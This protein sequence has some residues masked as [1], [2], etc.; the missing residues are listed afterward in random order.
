MCSAS[1][2]LSTPVVNGPTHKPVTR[3][4]QRCLDLMQTLP[5]ATPA[6]I[7]WARSKMAALGYFVTRGRHGKNSAVWCQECGHMDEVGLPPL[8]VDITKVGHVCSRCGR[9]LDV[10]HWSSRN[11][12]VQH[13]FHFAVVSACEDF[14]VARVFCINQYNAMGC[15]TQELIDNVFNVFVEIRTGKE[16]II[17]RKY[18]RNYNYFRWNFYE[19]YR[20]ARHCQ[21][22]SG[23]YVYEDIYDLSNMYIFPHMKIHPLLRRNGW[24]NR[25]THMRTSPV[26][27]WRGLLS[28]PAIEALAKNLQY[29]I[30]D[31][32]FSTG[33]PRR[34]K[35]SWM[36]IIR[37]CNRHHYIVNDAS[38]WFDYIDL[39]EYFH[40]DTRSPHYVCPAN[41]KQEHDRLLQKKKRIEDAKELR[42]QIA[43]SNKFEEQ[44]RKHRGRFFGICFGN[45]QITV[46]VISSVREMAEEGTA[47][48][49]CVYFNRY[50]DHKSHPDSLILSARDKNGR[51]L[52]TVEVNVKTWQVIQS[53]GVGNLP[54]PFHDQIVDI[55]RQ[56]IHLFK[57]AV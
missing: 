12:E 47:M 39:L 29:N 6:Q 37:I 57:K 11:K 30:I 28:D 23:Y 1:Y 34:D 35:S 22:F 17:S 53:R 41:L 16:V 38:L 27:I 13:D 3:L 9:K 31:Y 50:Y 19:P 24:K 44:Y 18:S 48:H 49:H 4:Q 42:R 10:R 14:Q 55:V 2:L 36:P 7:A 32:W 15:H 54:T 25:M 46:M 45:A 56:N 33:G 5:P 8:L 40:K 51:R 43:Q 52:E 20:V 26:L 21:S